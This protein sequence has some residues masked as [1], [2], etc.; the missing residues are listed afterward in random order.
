MLEELLELARSQ[1]RMLSTQGYSGP[2]VEQAT[3]L[4][5]QVGTL[6]RRRL[7]YE[8]VI[9]EQLESIFEGEA[10]LRV[11]GKE[12]DYLLETTDG[13]VVV[14]VKGRLTKEG[15]L[16]LVEQFEDIPHRLTRPIHGMVIVTGKVSQADLDF[17]STYPFL[18]SITAWIPEDGPLALHQEFTKL[19]AIE[20]PPPQYR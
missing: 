13:L 8:Q 12:I 11:G 6:K 10:R 14:E 16:F 9:V 1:L 15:F 4:Q 20:R 7:A 17:A 19:G 18:K 3:Q 2:F 5:P